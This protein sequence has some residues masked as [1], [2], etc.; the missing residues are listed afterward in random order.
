[1]IKDNCCEKYCHSGSCPMRWRHDGYNDCYMFSDTYPKA[2]D[3]KKIIKIA[4]K[5]K[6]Q[7]L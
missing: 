2:W 4:K 7:H 5:W 3:I 6:K 1:M